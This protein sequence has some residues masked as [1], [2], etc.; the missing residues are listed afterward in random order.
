[1]LGGSLDFVMKPADCIMQTKLRLDLLGK[2]ATIAL[3]VGLEFVDTELLT[4]TSAKPTD[5]ISSR[6][7]VAM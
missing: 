6:Y 1:M 2:L 5:Q 4:K 7:K 3:S